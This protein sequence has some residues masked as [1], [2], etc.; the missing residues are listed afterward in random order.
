MSKLSDHFWL[1]DFV[2]KGV[3]LKWGD[4]SIWF[5]DYRM[6]V[7]AE[8]FRVVVGRPVLINTWKDGGSLNG[9][10]YR[11]TLIPEYRPESQHSFGRAIDLSCGDMSSFEMVDVLKKYRDQWPWI[12]AYESPVD[13][14]I[15]DKDGKP[16]AY[17]LHADC[18]PLHAQVLNSAFDLFEVK[19]VK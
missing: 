8:K 18:R 11:N 4:N 12:T 13:T 9:R 1:E 2:P 10:G 3:W 6:T 17:W 19:P 15:K 16:T 5:I 7:F 14:M